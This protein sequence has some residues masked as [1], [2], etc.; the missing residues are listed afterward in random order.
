AILF[1]GRRREVAPLVYEAR[2]WSHGVLVGAGM[3]SETTAAA[4]GQMGVVRRDSMAMKPF[5]GYNFGDYWKH[6]LSFAGRAG[7]LPR[8]FHVNWFRQDKNGRFMWPGYGENLRVLR[9]ITDRCD[10]R[11]EAQDTP[12]GFV[13]RRQD[14]DVSGLNIDGAALDTLLSVDP[15]AWRHEVES[16]GKYLDEFRERV[17]AKLR[18]ELKDVAA[19]LGSG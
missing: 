2:S 8:I 17:P 3:A 19:R 10:G 1:G 7:K 16:I 11:V 14:I 15:V 13:P 18:D 6:W 5:C 12:I 4:V 9:W